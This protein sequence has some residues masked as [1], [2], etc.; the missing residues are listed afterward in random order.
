MV[1]DHNTAV[2]ARP[3]LAVLALGGQLL[4]ARDEA[5]TAREATRAAS[6][7]ARA[8]L[9][10]IR[11]G[12]GVLLVHGSGPQVGRELLRSDEAANKVPPRPLEACTAATQGTVGYRLVQAIR[13]ALK[14]ADAPRPV[15][16]T[17]TQVLVSPQ[18]PAFG[19]P[20]L[21][22]GPLY[23]AWRAR[24]LGR[25]H[26]WR[27][28]EEAGGGWRQMVASPRP[29]DV[30]D[31]DGVELLLQAGH[32]VV[33]GGGGGV[34]MIVNAR[35][36]LVGVDGV[37]DKDHT[38]AL[39]ANLLGADL[40]VFLTGVDQVFANFGGTEQRPLEQLT[41]H[42]LRELHETGQFDPTSMGPKVEATLDFLD[43]GGDL[44][45]ITSPARLAAALADRAGTRVARVSGGHGSTRQ[46]GLFPDPSEETPA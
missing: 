25:A 8:V 6:R 11:E 18:D 46:L 30:L 35:G 39:L 20:A 38:A 5:G 14:A 22:V 44:V 16:A 15:S 37:V 34:P 42:E 29:V 19:H 10:L 45:V 3:P 40:I 31:V 24:E 27:L 12:Y 9:T 28:V 33:A 26:G 43:E 1:S 21:P 17:L 7:A 32:I 41:R 23:S 4:C 13:N 2:P 36:D